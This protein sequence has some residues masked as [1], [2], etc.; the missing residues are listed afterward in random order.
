YKT[1]KYNNTR[2]TSSTRYI[3]YE[4]PLSPIDQV[5]RNFDGRS[6]SVATTSISNVRVLDKILFKNGSLE[7]GLVQDRLDVYQG[8]ASQ[9]DIPRVGSFTVFDKNQQQIFERA[10]VAVYKAKE[11]GRNQVLVY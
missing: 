10:D 1:Y 6:K 11:K 3:L 5:G 8:G 9:Y 7:F 2:V 4:G